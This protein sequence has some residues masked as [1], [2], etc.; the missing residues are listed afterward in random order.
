MKKNIFITGA[1]SGIGLATANLFAANGF[2]LILNARREERL[3][4]IKDKLAQEY[5]TN[6]LL[7]PYDVRNYNEVKDA[8][9]SIPTEFLPIDILINN[10]GLALGLNTLENGDINHWETMLDTNVK[11][12]L[13]HSKLLLPYLKKSQQPHIINIG[14]IAGKEIYQNGN[15]Y[16]ASKHAVD[17]LTKSM[18]LELANYPIKVSAINPGAVETEFSVVRFE[19]D[20]DKAAKVY[21][22]FDNLVA[23]DIAE[24]IYWVASRPPHVN[25]NDIIIMPTTQPMAGVIYRK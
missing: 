4:S 6:V 10:A 9:K 13:Y 12:L 16:C 20:I 19:G 15:V 17:A 7:L 5:N 2:N 22:G 1:S 8:I 11:G 24:T 23:E 25:I 14:S 21:E 3:V 18:R